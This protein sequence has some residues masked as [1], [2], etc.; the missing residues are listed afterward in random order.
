MPFE[1]LKVRLAMLLEQMIHQPEDV[2]ELQETLR[3]EL[4]E[5]K[6]SGLPLPQDLVDLEQQLEDQLN[7]PNKG[8]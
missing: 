2:H 5:L 1:S 8:K 4:A 6:A 7:L 3:E